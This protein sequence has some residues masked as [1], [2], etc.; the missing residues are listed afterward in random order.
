MLLRVFGRGSS[1][2]DQNS[3]PEQGRWPM[4]AVDRARRYT[5]LDETITILFSIDYYA[6]IIPR[7]NVLCVGP[8][9][10]VVR[11]RRCRGRHMSRRKGGREVSESMVSVD[12]ETNDRY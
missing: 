11:Q 1:R 4:C 12:P 5:T 7:I 6:F 3:L 2:S 10:D 9:S 8:G